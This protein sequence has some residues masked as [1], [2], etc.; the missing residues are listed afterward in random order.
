[1]KPKAR[2]AC[3]ALWCAAFVAGCGGAGGPPAQDA[4]PPSLQE[5][6][7]QL[8]GESCDYSWPETGVEKPAGIFQ[9]LNRALPYAK[10]SCVLAAA[11]RLE[12]LGP[13][14][15]PA[16]PA[17]IK[18][19]REGPNDYD[20]GD[21]VISTRSGI[22]SALAATQ[23]PRAI[24]ALAEA[25][26][27]AK[28]M[29][30]A[31]SAAASDGRPAAR[32]AIVLGLASFGPAAARHWEPVAEV[33]RQRI[34]DPG[35]LERQRGYYEMSAA[36]T[37]ASK[38][39]QARSPDQTRYVV[40]L[41]AIEAARAKLN[42]ASPDYIREFELRAQDHEANA[43]A[44]ALGKFGVAEAGPVLVEAL[45][46]FA[47]AEAAASALA[48]LRVAAPGATA[49]LRRVLESAS[50][51]PRAR[52]AAGRTLGALGSVE[53]APALIR[54]LPDDEL[55]EASAQGLGLL[56]PRAKA[57]LPQLEAVL[58][59]PPLDRRSVEG[60]RRQLAKSAAVRAIAAIDP[61]Y[62]ISLLPRFLFEH[63]AGSTA[64]EVLVQLDPR[65]G[66]VVPLISAQTK[67]A[68]VE[69]RRR[70]VRYLGRFQSPA[71]APVLAQ[72]LADSDSQVRRAAANALRKMAGDA[73]AALPALQAALARSRDPVERQA[74]ESAISAIRPR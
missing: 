54:G 69:M 20:T 60:T 61:D 48:E 58:G 4:H 41:A 59:R 13:A 71:A 50:Y 51:G 35:Y 42:R 3:V 28:P 32:H 68:D 30:R 17:L 12:E 43:A 22:A 73:A 24:D 66:R 18:A 45:D 63:D 46:D 53:A 5:L 57:A 15:A 65:G 47:A 19:L 56:G 38:E 37:V 1:M 34:A 10:H 23:D 26:K 49:A 62:A 39:I 74:L 16:V 72:S 29:E 25:L 21:G 33:L 7:A 9:L 44:R 14:A 2:G 6:I 31:I 55:M 36:T 67:A 64:Q 11:R 70:A 52:A 8:E 27:S 40:P